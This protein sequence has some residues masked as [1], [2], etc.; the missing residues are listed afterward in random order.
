MQNEIKNKANKINDKVSELINNKFTGSVTVI[1]HL[2]EGRLM[3]VS[4]NTKEKLVSVVN[5]LVYLQ[6]RDFDV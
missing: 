3:D 2:K 5:N 6:N 1:Y 4:L